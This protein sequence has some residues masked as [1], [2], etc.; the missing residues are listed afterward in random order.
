M[1]RRPLIRVAGGVGPSIDGRIIGY[2]GISRGHHARAVKGCR[3]GSG[4]YRRPAMIH[5]RQLR[6]I[7]AGHLFVLHL[8]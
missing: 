4:R 5:G 6:A 7:G 2:R 8:G 3:L 1:I